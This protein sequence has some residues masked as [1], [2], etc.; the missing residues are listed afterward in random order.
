[1]KDGIYEIDYPRKV[2]KLTGLYVITDGTLTPAE[3]LLK[4]VEQAILGGARLVQ[5]RNKSDARQRC[6]AQARDLA[7]LCTEHDVPLIIN[8]DVAMADSSGADGVHLGMDDSALYIARSL[9][10]EEAII[11]IS[12]YNDLDQAIRAESDGADYVA[13]GSF[14][15]SPTKPRAIRADPA[16]LRRAT[17]RLDIPICA[18]GGITADNA[19]T[20]IQAGTDMVAVISDVFASAYPERRAR[21]IA[22]I[23]CKYPANPTHRKS[24]A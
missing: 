6:L 11:G 5:Y 10:D 24:I 23:F 20:L 9:L 2:Q 8:D 19:G 21:N 3:S 18:I 17:E 13:F 22:Q 12:C 7:R 14:F 16:L 1:M 4:Q 15:S